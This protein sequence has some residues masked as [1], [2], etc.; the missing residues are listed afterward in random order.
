MLPINFLTVS[1]AAV[2]AFVLGFLFH[3]PVTGKLSMKLANIRMTGNEKM[4]DMVPMMV[5]NLVVNFI[6]AY[7]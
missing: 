7:H 3:G 4:A 1:L 6:T 5:W 2:V